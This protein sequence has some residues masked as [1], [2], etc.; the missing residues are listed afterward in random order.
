M[1]DGNTPDSTLRH[2]YSALQQAVYYRLPTSDFRLPTSDFRLIHQRHLR[3]VAGPLVDE[4][5]SLW[6][7]VEREAVR[8]E[9]GQAQPR[10]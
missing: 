8:Y 5:V 4:A 1:V 2:H 3:G 10:Q 7:V 6:R 9:F